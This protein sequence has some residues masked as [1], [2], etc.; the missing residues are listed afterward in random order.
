[1]PA[2]A[3]RA[4]AAAAS[5]RRASRE[6]P[7]RAEIEAAAGVRPPGSLE[8]EQSRANDDRKLLVDAV[9]VLSRSR[10]RLYSC[11]SARLGVDSI[12]WKRGYMRDRHE[13][14]LPQILAGKNANASDDK[15][16]ALQETIPFAREANLAVHPGVRINQYEMGADLMERQ[17][18][19]Q[20]YGVDGHGLVRSARKPVASLA[21]CQRRA[22]RGS[23][24]T[25]LSARLTPRWTN[26]SSA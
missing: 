22:P 18:P 11:R 16:L 9:I 2:M 17:E 20:F 19:G 13:E 4:A 1:V 24:T 6:L 8:P 26:S 5:S 3:R 23:P 12:G 15:P 10:G 7:D 25:I 14:A 21:R